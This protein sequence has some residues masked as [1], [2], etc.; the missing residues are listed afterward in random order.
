MIIKSTVNLGFSGYAASWKS[1]PGYN[2]QY[3]EQMT[4][5]NVE[6]LVNTYLLSELLT[7]SAAPTMLNSQNQE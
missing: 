7:Q 4:M 2:L 6:N 5:I 1:C 3:P